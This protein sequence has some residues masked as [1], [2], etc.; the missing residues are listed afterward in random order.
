MHKLIATKNC[1]CLSSRSIFISSDE[2]KSSVHSVS[3]ANN[4]Q[5]V[6]AGPSWDMSP[7]TMSTA[8]NSDFYAID[9]FSTLVFI[10]LSKGI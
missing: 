3:T 6:P 7:P 5:G 9:F 8:E 10:E 2:I 1:R 4:V